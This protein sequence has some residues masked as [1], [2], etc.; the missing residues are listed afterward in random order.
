MESSWVCCHLLKDVMP[1]GSVS[2]IN[3]KWAPTWA[4]MGSAAELLK[5]LLYNKARRG[6]KV[7]TGSA[8]IN[9]QGSKMSEWGFLFPSLP[10]LYISYREAKLLLFEV[11]SQGIGKSQVC[12]I[13]NYQVLSLPEKKKRF[14]TFKTIS[15]VKF[16][17]CQIKN[18]VKT[19]ATEDKLSLKL[20]K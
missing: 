6:V 20:S 4:L 14:K 16:Q 18:Q 3:D 17:A 15:Q 7:P 13:K 10:H 8:G 2:M 5:Q 19:W 9:I 11:K 12:Q 1:F